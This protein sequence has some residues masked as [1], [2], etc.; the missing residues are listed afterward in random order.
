[1]PHPT[2]YGPKHDAV[3]AASA[4]ILE[5]ETARA[6]ALADVEARFAA[7][8]AAAHERLE[9]ILSEQGNRSDVPVAVPTR[10]PSEGGRGTSQFARL[11][12]VLEANPHATRAD[13][14]CAV[15]GEASENTKHRIRSLLHYGVRAGVLRVEDGRHVVAGATSVSTVVVAALK[16]E[17][18]DDAQNYPKSGD[19]QVGRATAFLRQRGGGPAP[20]AEIAAAVGA[21]STSLRAALDR[22]VNDG[23]LAKVGPGNYALPDSTGGGN[24][25]AGMDQAPSAPQSASPPGANA[26]QKQNGFS[27]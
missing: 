16:P 11:L 24:G 17:K 23:R 4:K 5:I 2:P 8:S 12:P 26:A 14:A 21:K 9:A 19:S 25:G 20:V 13:M 15:F 22:A 10:A 1:M 7:Q 6:A 18:V 3:I 27:W